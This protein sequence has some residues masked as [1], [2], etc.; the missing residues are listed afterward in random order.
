MP[1]D[2]AAV[3]GDR[4]GG[5]AMR[6]TVLALAILAAGA[7]AFAADDDQAKKDLKSLEG[8]WK[9]VS[10]TKNGKETEKDKLDGLIV[11][12]KGDKWEVKRDDKVVLAGT[13]KLVESKKHKAADWTVTSDGDLKDHTVQGIFKVEKDKLHHCYGEKRPEAFESKEDSQVTYAVFERVK[14]KKE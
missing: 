10:Q 5:W 1:P 13:V 14:K 8:T 11:T 7:V 4:S 6:Q 3:G 9:I 2:A 12:I